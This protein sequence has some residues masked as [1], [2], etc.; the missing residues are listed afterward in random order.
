MTYTSYAELA[1]AET[2]GVD[3]TR[4]LTTVSGATWIAIAI[5]GG[6]IEPG[7]GE[8]AAA[9]SDSLMDCYVF[10]GIKPSGNSALHIES[11]LFDEPTC[12]AAVAASLRTLSFHGFA[13]DAGVAVSAVGGLDATMVRRVKRRLRDAGFALSDPPEEISGEDPDNICNK[14]ASSAGM[15]IEMSRAQREA[16]YI[17]GNLSAASRAAGNTTSVFDAYVAA[18]RSAFNGAGHISIT[19]VNSSRYTLLSA[20]SAD[21]SLRASVATDVIAAGGSHYCALAARYADTSNS[22]LARLAFTTSSTVQLTIR[23]RVGG[24]ESQVGT[25]TVT[26]P[27]PYEAGTR[28]WVAFSAVS[29]A[30]KASAWRDG[31]YPPGWL[32]EETDADLSAAGSIGMRSI[33]SSVCS[34]ALPV[35]VTWDDFVEG[36]T[37]QQ[38]DVIRGLDSVRRT[39][40]IGT[41]VGL[42]HPGV[43]EMR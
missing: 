37:I 32:I 43:A 14:N 6:G 35:V 29:T 1:A 25:T 22:Y 28:F 9:V 17:D 36:P 40:P 21:V 39:W 5:H 20:P 4:T 38:L 12:V 11:D 2:E 16:F 23:K 31:A 19:A 18:V 42:W 8:V 33:L 30:L 34:N 15:Q 13:G 26:L 41:A 27:D 10:A 3:Y 7:T 24:A